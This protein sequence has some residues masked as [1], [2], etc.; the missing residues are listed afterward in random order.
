MTI[1]T[2]HFH[3]AG[4][5]AAFQPAHRRPRTGPFS[6]GQMARAEN[7]AF[8]HL[9]RQTDLEKENQRRRIRAGLDSGGRLRRAAA[10]GDDGGHRGQR[11]DEAS[12]ATAA[13]C[14]ARWTKSSSRSP[15]RCS[16]SRWRFFLPSSSG[17]SASRFNE[18]TIPR[19]I[20]WVDPDGPAGKAGFASGRPILEVDGHPVKHFSPPS[21]D[22][23]TWRIVTST[24]TNIAIKYL[25]DGKEKRWL[26]PCRIIA[27]EMV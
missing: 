5:G 14:F 9:V 16:V 8:R 13:E 22:S 17:A 25:R 1:L 15:G 2:L 21:Q 23:V 26:I 11:T 3:R 10:N 19:T 6:C 4:S 12:V 18:R 20:G 7:R 24:G 27:D